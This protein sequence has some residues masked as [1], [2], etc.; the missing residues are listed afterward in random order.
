MH[1]GAINGIEV[2]SRWQKPRFMNI[3]SSITATRIIGSETLFKTSSIITNIAAIEIASTTLKSWSVISII[4]L[5]QGASPMSIPFLSY[6]LSISLSL[7]ICSFTSS[8]AVAYSEFITISFQ[9][10]LC[11]VDFAS[12]GII[13]SGIL[14]PTTDS[15]PNTNLDKH[16]MRRTDVEFLFKLGICNRAF[17]GLRQCFGHIVINLAVCLGVAP[18]SRTYKH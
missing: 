4:S 7:V 12:S 17:H 11:K 2:P 6:F 15:S 18:E 13:S 1:I 14:L 5:V 8:V 3:A 16:H 10:S 9:L